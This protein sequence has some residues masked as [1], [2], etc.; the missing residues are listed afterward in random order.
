[1]AASFVQGRIRKENL[2]VLVETS[3]VHCQ[4]PM[5]FTLSSEM[6]LT[7]RSPGSDPMVFMPDIDWDNFREPTIIDAF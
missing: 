3:C 7:D 5:S 6:E 4:Q 1:M 2:S